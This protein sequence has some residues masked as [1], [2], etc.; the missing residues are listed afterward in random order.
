MVSLM[1]SSGEEAAAGLVVGL[2]REEAARGGGRASRRLFEPYGCCELENVG[3]P[4]SSCDL[5]ERRGRPTLGRPISY[6][7]SLILLL[8][9]KDFVRLLL[10]VLRHQRE[11]FFL[12]LQ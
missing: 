6:T 4:P 3:I 9:L 11:A 8:L 1:T 10:Q 2:G 7:P 5:K 12:V